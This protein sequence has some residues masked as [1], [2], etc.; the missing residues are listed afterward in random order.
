VSIINTLP[1]PFSIFAAFRVETLTNKGLSSLPPRV[2]DLPNMKNF[3]GCCPLLAWTTDGRAKEQP[4]LLPVPRGA[5]VDATALSIPTTGTSLGNGP[6]RTPKP[7][8]RKFA[9][10][11]L[12]RQDQGW[13]AQVPT[14]QPPRWSWS[15]QKTNGIW[16]G[17]THGF[18]KHRPRTT[19]TAERRPKGSDPTG[20]PRSFCKPMRLNCDNDVSSRQQMGRLLARLTSYN[21]AQAPIRTAQET[22]SARPRGAHYVRLFRV[23]FFPSHLPRGQ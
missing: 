22:C 20:N 10:R 8:E 7:Q 13:T 21:H 1:R 17:H 19:G 23:G 12:S 18:L 16:P 4:S 6:S 2:R 11:A 9:L 14:K 15:P 3:S 5:C